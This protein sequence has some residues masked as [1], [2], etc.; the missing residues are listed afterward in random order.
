MLAKR[1]DELTARIY[2]LGSI[3]VSQTI[4]EMKNPIEEKMNEEF[5]A[6]VNELRHCVDKI[7]GSTTLEMLL[8]ELHR[9]NHLLLEQLKQY[10]TAYQI[11]VKTLL[12]LS[13]TE[14]TP[15][16]E[17]NSPTT[18][19]MKNDSTVFL[20]TIKRFL[21]AIAAIE[22][23]I[24]QVRTDIYYEKKLPELKLYR[25][26]TATSQLKSIIE[27]LSPAFEKY[28]FRKNSL[29]Q[30]NLTCDELESKLDSNILPT[31][32]LLESL[33]HT[34]LEMKKLNASTRDVELSKNLNDLNNLITLIEQDTQQTEFTAEEK[35]SIPQ[36]V[37]YFYPDLNQFHSRLRN[38][39]FAPVI[40][41]QDIALH[42]Q[43]KKIY[44]EQEPDYAENSFGSLTHAE[45]E[46]ADRK[47]IKTFNE[48]MNILRE[49]YVEHQRDYGLTD[50]HM[51]NLAL[52]MNAMCTR[53]QHYDGQNWIFYKEVK[54]QFEILMTEIQN[55]EISHSLKKRVLQ[56]LFDNLGVCADVKL[57][58]E[59]A[60]AAL[61][62]LKSIDALLAKFRYNLILQFSA[63]YA[64]DKNIRAGLHVHV[65]NAFLQHAAKLGINQKG[66]ESTENIDEQYLDD[67]R[68]TS[69]DYR[70]FEKRFFESDYTP[71][72]CIKEIVT[73][74]HNEI[75]LRLK[76]AMPIK[77]TSTKGFKD[78]F[79]GIPFVADNPY[80]FFSSYDLDDEE[81]EKFIQ[82]QRENKISSFTF[83]REQL[84]LKGLEQL[85][86]SLCHLLIQKY[87][88]NLYEHHY[89]KLNAAEAKAFGEKNRF[90]FIQEITLS[91]VKDRHEM[92]YIGNGTDTHNPSYLYPPSSMPLES[93]YDYHFKLSLP[94]LRALY[95]KGYRNFSDF[96]INV[97]TGFTNDDLSLL[98]ECQFNKTDFGGN[99][100]PEQF[101][102]LSKYNVYFN[103]LDCKPNDTDLIFIGEHCFERAIFEYLNF[104]SCRESIIKT[105]NPDVRRA[106]LNTI[107]T[108]KIG[109]SSDNHI[110]ARNLLKMFIEAND[111]E[112]VSKLLAIKVKEPWG[113]LAPLVHYT[114]L[115]GEE[116]LIKN[117]LNNGDKELAILLIK[118]NCINKSTYKQVNDELDR[119]LNNNHIDLAVELIE[120]WDNI[121]KETLLKA[122]DYAIKNDNMALYNKVMQSLSKEKPFEFEQAHLLTAINNKAYNVARAMIKSDLFILSDLSINIFAIPELKDDINTYFSEK[123]N[124]SLF[125]EK[126]LADLFLIHE[127]LLSLTQNDYINFYLKIKFWF[128]NFATKVQISTVLCQKLEEKHLDEL[129]KLFSNNSD[130]SLYF[131]ASHCMSDPSFVIKMLIQNDLI[132]DFSLLS[133]LD[134]DSIS[135]SKEFKSFIGMVYNALGVILK[136]I[137]N[138]DHEIK[139]YFRDNREKIYNLLLKIIPFCDKPQLLMDIWNQ[140]DFQFLNANQTEKLIHALI[141]YL[142]NHYPIEYQT[143]LQSEIKKSNCN[144]N[145][146]LALSRLSD[147]SLFTKALKFNALFSSDRIEYLNS[148]I[149]HAENTKIID[150]QAISALIENNPYFI[151]SIFFNVS[152]L[153]EKNTENLT[154][155]KQFIDTFFLP[156]IRENKTDFLKQL[157]NQTWNEILNFLNYPTIFSTISIS[158]NQKT[159][160]VR[161]LE[162]I[163]RTMEYVKTINPS[164]D[165]KTTWLNAWRET[166]KTEF[167]P[168]DKIFASINQQE[169]SPHE[170]ESRQTLLDDYMIYSLMKGETTLLNTYLA[171]FNEMAIFRQRYPA[172]DITKP[173][174]KDFLAIVLRHASPQFLLDFLNLKKSSV[175]KFIDLQDTEL[176]QSLLV[177]APMIVVKQRLG[178]QKQVPEQIKEFILS[179]ERAMKASTANG[180][181]NFLEKHVNDAFSHSK[182]N[183]DKMKK[184]HLDDWK[185]VVKKAND[186]L[187]LQLH[188]N[189]ITHDRYIELANKIKK[190]EKNFSYYRINYDLWDEIISETKKYAA[191]LLEKISLKDL[192]TMAKTHNETIQH[193]STIYIKGIKIDISQLNKTNFKGPNYHLEKLTQLHELLILASN[194]QSEDVIQK[195]QSNEFQKIIKLHRSLKTFFS[196]SDI[197]A[198][199]QFYNKVLL[200][201]HPLLKQKEEKREHKM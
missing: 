116:A 4:L 93:V 140:F 15:E 135:K 43:I 64:K 156:A 188:R 56:D 162:T 40:Q 132:K 81:E 108:I 197:S 147:L 76:S 16:T 83:N 189:E 110:S 42:D 59:D 75:S 53:D 168:Y 89:Q 52:F 146:V 183:V 152:D 157:D 180:F 86:R 28:K 134:F 185:E 170:I 78:L 138:N 45:E 18:D 62:E 191:H 190:I 11:D 113:G 87:Q 193:V 12:D 160:Y 92:N 164:F 34:H 107:E 182:N 54:L 101:L 58:I 186:A 126:K 44:H 13:K 94:H 151:Y 163:L 27:R 176:L 55:P 159:F 29:E 7:D 35:S 103:G 67:I 68:I 88:K 195:I 30:L 171:N 50:Y 200:L 14:A 166:I 153:K 131:A 80:Y 21:K 142:K 26:Q 184:S 105:K 70:K 169:T 175:P 79:K 10:A 179:P 33:K 100:T 99:I 5:I 48:Q 8:P 1:Q 85:T 84:F 114:H 177:N 63:Q 109:D 77:I 198:G 20:N 19:E 9:I 123:I 90:K 141:P 73:Y 102:A 2:N 148:L 38:D 150:W 37:F 82:F 129:E 143:L 111:I 49:Y 25:L 74:F 127:P 137:E 167:F 120:H 91:C 161:S 144:H 154:I 112:I 66:F 128:G 122:L 104:T 158:H 173:E 3:R 39:A 96:H 41:K 174:G 124:T 155:R 172:M 165:N 121:T 199:E 72:T 178:D 196:S 69:A 117:L 71:E 65:D 98:N 139:L 145:I 192:E 115:L 133:E 36:P 187:E 119:S 118:N 24:L 51:E 149:K 106:F 22:S 32:A 31:N 97:G 23:D 17:P 57:H 125:I 47:L 46:K 6:G 60:V 95:N 130:S 194:T 201:T 136:G 61:Q 181:L